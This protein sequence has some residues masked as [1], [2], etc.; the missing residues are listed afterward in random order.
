M[1]NQVSD[2]TDYFFNKYNKKSIFLPFLN[3]PY[4]KTRIS[5]VII[6]NL[7]F[8]FSDF[9]PK[10]LT[11]A[12]SLVS[13]NEIRRNIVQIAYEELGSGS[14][15]AIHSHLF[16]EC[17]DNN[18][19]RDHQITCEKELASLLNKIQK[20]PSDS[21]ILG[22]NLGLEIPAN[23][24]IECIFNAITTNKEEELKIEK[25]PFFKIHRINEDEHIRLN[26][27]NFL[28]FCKSKE[29]VN[30]FLEG[31][32]IAI[33]FWESFWSLATKEME[34]FHVLRS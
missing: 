23:E 27:K 14:H 13:T 2:W 18:F 11:K 17:L 33:N 9:M 6:G 16:L 29:E 3:S 7:W 4:Y 24:N 20:N 34:S 1:K 10:Y 28:D 21:F 32:N 25:M 19:K 26:V 22:I 15:K 31:F 12:A 30:E 5:K 8:E